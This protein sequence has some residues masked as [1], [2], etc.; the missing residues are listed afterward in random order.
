MGLQQFRTWRPLWGFL[1]CLLCV[2][3]LGGTSASKA[4]NDMPLVLI[5]DDLPLK[6]KLKKDL[7]EAKEKADSALQTRLRTLQEV[8]SRARRGADTFAV[9]AL[10]WRGKWALVKGKLHIGKE[11]AQAKFLGDAFTKHV[12]N[13]DD[14][15]VALETAVHGYISDLDLVQNELLV[16]LRA[17]LADSELGR[18]GKLPYLESDKS[19]LA[20]FQKLT[21]AVL[22]ALKIDLN[23]E[24][25]RQS[26]GFAAMDLATPI[27]VRIVGV[28]AAELGL[29]AGILGTG[30]VSGFATLGIGLVV[31]V[32]A[33]Q[34]IAWALKAA[35]YDPAKE[36][37][38]KVRSTLDQLE[39]LMIDGTKEKPGLRQELEKV[40]KARSRIQEAVVNKLLLEGA[41]S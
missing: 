6:E 14:L 3:V 9:E 28:V 23:M 29:E 21:K 1:Q 41:G 13:G 22:P 30:A 38:E 24:L 17:D 11:D 35:G 12:L 4:A 39:R 25:L 16:R 20:E 8:F 2:C 36:I 27:V 18:S 34:V 26:S 40:G 10:S 15:K 37:A 31:G 7:A 32:I 33:D 5:G 19:F